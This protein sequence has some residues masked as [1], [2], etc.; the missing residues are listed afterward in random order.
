MP[1][2]R[3]IEIVVAPQIIIIIISYKTLTHT[4]SRA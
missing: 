1:F 2:F 4:V 3:F